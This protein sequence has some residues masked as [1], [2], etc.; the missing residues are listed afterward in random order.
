M[1]EALSIEDK[2]HAENM[3]EDLARV[4]VRLMQIGYERIPFSTLYS[5]DILD[6]IMC[7]MSILFLA[8]HGKV[9]LVQKNFP[10]GEITIISHLD[11]MGQT[12]DDMLEAPAI[13]L[14]PVRDEHDDDDGDHHAVVQQIAVI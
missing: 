6:R 2:V 13:E 11:E 4:T 5:D 12:L 3:E 1:G 10:H 7:F 14:V 9:E 8:Q